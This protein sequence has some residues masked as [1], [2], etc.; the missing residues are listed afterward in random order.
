MWPVAKL[1]LSG[2][3]KPNVLRVLFCELY[4]ILVNF[5]ELTLLF[6]HELIIEAV[7]RLR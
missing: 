1:K 5:N 3:D 7:P 6:H 4:Y 2:S